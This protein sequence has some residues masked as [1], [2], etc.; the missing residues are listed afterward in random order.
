MFSKTVT[1]VCTALVLAAAF[2]SVA[3]AGSNSGDWWRAYR[4]KPCVSGE[5]ST[6]SAYPSWLVCTPRA[7]DL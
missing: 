7:G 3:Q 1:T 4:N 5:Q 2:G 6:I